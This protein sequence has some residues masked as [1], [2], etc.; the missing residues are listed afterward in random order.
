M[1]ALL[2]VIALG[3]YI[4]YFTC[5]WCAKH[6]CYLIFVQSSFNNQ[7]FENGKFLSF[8]VY[9]HEN[10]TNAQYPIP[11]VWHIKFDGLVFLMSHLITPV[12]V[13]RNTILESTVI[14]HIQ[15]KVIR[16]LHAVLRCC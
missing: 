1:H 3:F 4:L 2:L 15:I 11:Q 8:F 13:L 9:F 12:H 14:C 10:V 7:H 5:C 16:V 6:I